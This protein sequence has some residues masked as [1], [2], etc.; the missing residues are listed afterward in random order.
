MRTKL[1]Y[2]DVTSQYNSE[3]IYHGFDYSNTFSF[4]LP[5]VYSVNMNSPEKSQDE[6]AG[7]MGAGGGGLHPDCSE[8]LL[9]AQG[10]FTRAI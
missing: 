4:D 5:P 2:G 1:Q 6:S 3:G 10:I 9:I 7:T 8:N